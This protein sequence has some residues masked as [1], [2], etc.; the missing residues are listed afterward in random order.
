[1]ISKNKV[2]LNQFLVLLHDCTPNLKNLLITDNLLKNAVS[3]LQMGKNPTTTLYS[4]TTKPEKFFD[5]TKT[6]KKAKITKQAHAFKNYAH[7][8][9]V[10][11]LN[12]FYPKLKR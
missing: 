1:M 11:I 8:Y 7:T 2:H 4:D 10:E 9:N 5:K 6:T 3:E 12:S